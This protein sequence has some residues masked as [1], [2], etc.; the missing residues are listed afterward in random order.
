MNRKKFLLSA[1]AAV[2]G[3]SFPGVMRALGRQVSQPAGD[4]VVFNS[5]VSGNNSNNLLVRLQADCISYKPALTIIMIGTNDMC[6]GKHVTPEK[7]GQNL[8]KLIAAI[9]AAGSKVLLLS[10][11]P[12]YEPYF[13]TRHPADF[14]APEGPAGKKAGMN[15]VIKAVAEKYQTSF[16]DAGIL[17]E[18][19]GNIGTDKDSLIRN[20]AN[21]GKTDGVHPTL[22]GYRFL[23]LAISQFIQYHQLPTRR[24]VC[25]GD[26]ITRGD[27]SVDHE[28][29]P[30]YLK[31]LLS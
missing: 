18:K 19:I 25:F 26:S 5:G 1:T 14:F 15:A 9:T 20:E 6:N 16:F 24:I 10:I 21:S 13:L 3:L 23:A 7:F 28:S 29:Y 11:L 17:F 8:G 4:V 12:F 27:G 30:A 22:N 2:A 31:K